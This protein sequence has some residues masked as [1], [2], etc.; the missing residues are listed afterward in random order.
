MKCQRNSTIIS[1]DLTWKFLALQEEQEGIKSS[2]KTSVRK[3]ESD[4]AYVNTRTMPCA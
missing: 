1:E 2:L 3:E 4:F